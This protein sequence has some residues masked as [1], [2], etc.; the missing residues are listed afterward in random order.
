MSKRGNGYGSEN[1]V[2]ILKKLKVSQNWN[3]YPAVV[4]PN[5]T[6]AKLKHNPA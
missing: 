5:C 4:E 1:R 3:L 2:N 6:G